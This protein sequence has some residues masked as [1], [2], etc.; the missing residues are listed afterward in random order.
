MSGAAAKFAIGVDYGTSSARV[1]VFD[2]A[3]GE[4]VGSGMYAYPSGVEGVVVSDA[5]P[6]LARQR[7]K[8]YLDGFVVACGA[9]VKDAS[10]R[11]AAG[12]T[13]FS[14][15]R[16]V[17][18]GV[19]ATGSTPIPVARDGTA[20]AMLPEFAN[21]PAAMAWL[22]KD[23][24]AHAEAAEITDLANKRGEPYLAKCGGAYSSEWYWSKMLKC[25]RSSARVAGAAHSWVEQSDFIPA[26]LTGNTAPGT[27]MRNVCAAG[28]KG[29]YNPAWGGLPSREFLE[30]LSPGFSRYRETYAER[31]VAADRCAG[32]LRAEVAARVGLP[33]GIPVAV[34]AIDAHMGAVGAGVAPGTLVKIIGTSTCDCMVWPMSE[35]LAD[36][37]GVCGIVPESILPGMH[38][39]EAGQSAVGDIFNWFA[40]KIAPGAYGPPERMHENLSGAAARLEPGESGLLALDWHNG[41][42]NVLTDPLLTGVIIG[43]TLH[44]TPP[45]IYRALIEATAF[46]ALRIIEQ[47]GAHGVRVDRVVNC[48]GIAEKSPLVMQIYADVCDRPMLVSRSA[49]TCAL[50][51]AVFAS[52]V[53]GA[54]PSVGEAQ[55][56][57][58]GVKEREYRPDGAR[59]AVYRE[60]YGLYRD[61]HDAFGVRGAGASL[62]RVMKELIRIRQNA[63]ARRA[64][65]G[66]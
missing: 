64:A 13:G 27:M 53:G 20:L 7:P 54:H 3:T 35:P 29:M 6:N 55:R 31:A 33:A 56:A 10:E 4:D 32:G 37:P 14:A 49:Q 48:G 36:I 61:L 22:W 59:A 46:G 21:D 1:V 40:G 9:A 23:H 34:G 66:R 51:A 8:D 16:V 57:M 30:A 41:N 65:E 5:D 39:I 25:E 19:D 24:T 18:I 45:E 11:A 50:G 15:D 62:H 44:T 63:R 12:K 43:E 58:T 60:L 47:I 38:G 2:A 42:R 26:W 17:G 52:V 28:H